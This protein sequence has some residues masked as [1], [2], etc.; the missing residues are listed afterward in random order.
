MS[1]SLFNNLSALTVIIDDD[2]INADA[3]CSCRVF[4]VLCCVQCQTAA[5]NEL[6]GHIHEVSVYSSLLC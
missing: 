6:F 5:L 1:L 3:R 2:D 4:S